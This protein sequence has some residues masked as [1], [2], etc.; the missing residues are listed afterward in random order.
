MS[1]FNGHRGQDEADAR[2]WKT[3]R[4]VHVYADARGA[5]YAQVW[6]TSPYDRWKRR[7]GW[8]AALPGKP[9]TRQR[10]KTLDA[11]K[12]AMEDAAR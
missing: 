9:E 1:R 6:P 4:G 8:Y 2:E 3:I 10:F 12:E 5:V 7:P 11:A